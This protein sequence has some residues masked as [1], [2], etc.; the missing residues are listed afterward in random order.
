LFCGWKGI[1]C[2]FL[3]FHSSSFPATFGFDVFTSFCLFLAIIT[4]IANNTLLP[5]SSSPPTDYFFFVILLVNVCLHHHHYHHRTAACV[6]E[7][8]GEEV[9][10]AADVSVY[11]V[12]RN[13]PFRQLST[14]TV[15]AALRT[16]DFSRILEEE[17]GDEE[18]EGAGSFSF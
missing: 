9:D 7:Q 14:A 3:Y 2:R 11:V 13:S 15:C 1:G 10:V 16:G 5:P 8:D 6:L 17:E 18:G 4:T 12:G